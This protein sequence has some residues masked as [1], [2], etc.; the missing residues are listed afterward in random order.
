ME[1]SCHDLCQE[2]MTVAGTQTPLV[3]TKFTNFLSHIKESSALITRSSALR[4]SNLLRNAGAKNEG[5]GMPIFVDAPPKLVTIA[6]TLV[7]FIISTHISTNPDNMM[8][9][10]QIHFQITVVQGTIKKTSNISRICSQP[11]QI[12]KVEK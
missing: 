11:C 9:T 1:I 6:A 12:S 3:G 10:S 8:K 5:G 2:V 7:R 4:S